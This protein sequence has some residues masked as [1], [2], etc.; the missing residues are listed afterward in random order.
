[1]SKYDINKA[2]VS[3]YDKFLRKFDLKHKPTASQL[4]EIAKHKRIA[5]LRDNPNK[6]SDDFM[7]SREQPKQQVREDIFS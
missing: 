2:F 3:L 4:E 1:M 6:F 5:N 7:E